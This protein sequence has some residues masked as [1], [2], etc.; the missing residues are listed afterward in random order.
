MS[1]QE[2][3]LF[4]SGRK[5][6]DIILLKIVSVIDQ[7]G[8][9]IDYLANGLLPYMDR[10]DYQV[11]DVHPTTPSTSQLMRFEKYAKDADIIDFQHPHIA[12]LL[13]NRY[14]WLSEKKKILTNHIPDYLNNSQYSM[15]DKVVSLNKTLQR[16]I[17]GSV[18][19]SLTVDTNFWTFNDKW[20]N[21]KNL[22]M[23]TDEIKQEKGIFEVAVA[24]RNLGLNLL[25]VGRKS[26][27]SYLNKVLETG[28]VTY[29]QE[30]S[31]EELQQLYYQSTLYVCNSDE[32]EIG[33]VSILEAMISGVPILSRLVGHVPELNKKNSMR[34][35][36]S[37]LNDVASLTNAIENLLSNEQ[38]LL[39][40][41]ERAWQIGSKQADE[42]RAYNYQK[43]YRSLFP[44]TPVSVIV[45]IY[46]YNHA[47]LNCLQSI[48]AQDYV[49]KEL[50]ICDDNPNSE[51]QSVI[52]EFARSV[53]FPVVYRNTSRKE[54]DYGLARARNVGIIEASGDILVFCDQR[55]SMHSNAISEF[56]KNLMP[57][58][59]LFGTKGIIKGFVENFSCVYR[60]DLI[61]A[62]M[63][64][65]RVDEYGGATQ[66]I[67]KRTYSQGFKHEL[68]PTANS[69][70]I[71]ESL[72]L[73]KRR[74][75]I[76]KMR[77]RLYRM[78][79]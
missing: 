22:I 60:N 7:I 32:S 44:G 54:N 65:E 30:M 53:S 63:F 23:V 57:K 19:I 20:T 36:E 42:R 15:F 72:S 34:L 78:N 13:L 56:V 55:I 73:S 62:G 24:C 8:S 16:R 45:T 31:K 41:R 40:M 59:W 75:E 49:N 52:E 71:V 10:Y 46:E 14:S 64:C 68:I 25:L 76:I 51:N 69:T 38:E 58:K 61:R 66:E 11:F 2:H 17:R 9:D 27:E 21:N 4:Y 50:I 74:P 29:R 48:A 6:W 37:P 39:V 77:N 5:G 12:L 26:D 67:F 28:R 3:L 43:L 79:F 70:F 47:I 1:K 35:L 18:F 33:P